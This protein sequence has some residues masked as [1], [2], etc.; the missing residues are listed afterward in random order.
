MRIVVSGTHASGKS[1]LI[2]EFAARHPG[3]AVLPDP[4]EELDAATSELDAHLFFEQLRV[5]A[6]R[7]LDTGAEDDVIAERGPLDFVAY[8]EALQQLRRPGRSSALFRQGVSIARAAMTEVDLLVL[9]PLE[10][11]SGIEASDDEDLEL[12]ATMN[13]ALLELADDGGLVGGALVREITGS[14][15]DRLAQLEDA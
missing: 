9:L 13:E 10:P 4:I 1:V 6:V 5:S 7:L 11:G 14:G 12:R 15:A 2:A 3:Y 8:L